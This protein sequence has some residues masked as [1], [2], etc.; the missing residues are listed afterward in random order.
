MRA[1]KVFEIKLCFLILALLISSQSRVAYAMSGPGNAGT[2]DWLK[3]TGGPYPR[4][5]ANARLWVKVSLERQ[6]VDIMDSGVSIYTMVVSTGLDSPADDRT[7]EGIFYIQPER[8]PSF[9][10]A[11]LG[12][13]ARYWV[14]W[15]N[16]GEYLFHS[17]PTDRKGNIIVNEARKLGTKASHGCI[18]LALPDARWIYRNIRVGTRVVIAP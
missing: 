3:P 14:S 4:L 1:S 15:L 12:E 11:K 9:Y 6:R 8:G 16:H 18:R 17:I 5:E 10:S 7:P 13:G 2:I